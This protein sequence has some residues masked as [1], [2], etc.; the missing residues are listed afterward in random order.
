MKQFKIL[1]LATFLILEISVSAQNADTSIINNKPTKKYSI[2][3]MPVLAANPTTGLIYGIAPGVSW[4]NGNPTNTSMSNFLGTLLYTS[5]KQLFFQV[6]GNTFLEG[7]KW[8]LTTDIRYNLNSQPTYGLGSDPVYSDHTI[9]GNAKNVSDDLFNGPTINE[10]MSFTHF[11]LYQSFM[12]RFENSRFF[13][14]LGYHLDIMSNIED[15]ELNLTSTPPAL[16][17]HYQYQK[18]KNLPTDK[19][20]QSGLS[21]NL[22]YDSRDNVA[23]PYSGM[24]AFASFKVNPTFLG[25]TASSSNLWLEYRNYFH[26][27]KTRPRNLLA[28]WA[29]GNFITGGNVPYMFLPASG[30][31]MF[32][33]SARPYTMGRFR[34]EDLAYTEAEWRFPLQKT[35][36]KFGAVLFMN[37]SS[38]SNR[39]GNIGLF[40]YPQLGYGGGLRYMLSEKN[41]VN[42][43]LD[44]GFGRNGA[45][46]LFLNLNEMF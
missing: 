36:E 3:P 7:D 24:L 19:Y 41:R 17:Y 26:L 4:T 44:Y 35:K 20:A 13:Y 27:S 15:H 11:R 5:K 1:V 16:T 30:W 18:I 9:V 14:G 12:K 37:L 43:S 42:I 39:L 32:G 38:A 8:I 46:G 31:D 33:R 22:S 21:F 34:G 29:Y 10:M 25:S 23:N 40:E 45:S 6:R 2:I 28:F